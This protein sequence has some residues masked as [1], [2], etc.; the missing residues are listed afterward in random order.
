MSK[1]FSYSHNFADIDF[2]AHPE[3]YRSG[4]GEQ[5]VLLIQPY[6]NELLPLWK[7]ATPQEAKQSADALYAKFKHY[8]AAK[9]FVGADLAR[10]FVQMGRTRSMRYFW[11]RGGHKYDGP[12]PAANKGQSG[13]HGRAVLPDSKDKDATKLT[14]AH[15]FKAKLDQALADPAYQQLKKEFEA[16]YP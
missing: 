13:A 1:P 9:D 15:I 16:K 7:F 8:V 5:G 6:R 3:L 2:R 14:S 10:K 12:V 11:H 4:R